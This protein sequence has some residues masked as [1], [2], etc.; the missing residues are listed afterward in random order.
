MEM[1]VSVCVSSVSCIIFH[2]QVCFKVRY[3][4]FLAHFL[5]GQRLVIKPALFKD[6]WIRFQ[7][8]I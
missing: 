4:T 2:K 1:G 5:S 6:F 7:I 8:Q 3:G